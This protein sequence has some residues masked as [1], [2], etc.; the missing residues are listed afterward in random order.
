MFTYLT[1]Y[2]TVQFL[3]IATSY[4]LFHSRRLKH[5]LNTEAE[6]NMLCLTKCVK[7]NYRFVQQN[8]IVQ[9]PSAENLQFVSGCNFPKY[10]FDAN[11]EN[12]LKLNQDK[13]VSSKNVS[14]KSHTKVLFTHHRWCYTRVVSKIK[15]CLTFSAL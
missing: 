15:S 12:T 4:H 8:K 3:P 2:T 11:R 1:S 10:L 13:H 7:L 6:K 5:L 14:A 9:R